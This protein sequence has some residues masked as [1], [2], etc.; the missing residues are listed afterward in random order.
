MNERKFRQIG[1]VINREM[2]ARQSTNTYNKTKN[3]TEN[4]LQYSLL[5]LA[6]RLI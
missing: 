5:N 3:K 2:L 1:R 6:Q 4:V